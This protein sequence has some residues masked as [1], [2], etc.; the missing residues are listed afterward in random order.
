MKKLLLGSIVL[1]VFSSSVAIFQMSC[2]KTSNAQTGPGSYTSPGI[3]LYDKSSAEIWKVKVDGTGN[4]K[5]NIV[6]PAGVQFQIGDGGAYKL[7]G[8]GQNIIFQARNTT[9]NTNQLYRCNL[10]GGD[11]QIVLESPDPI[12]LGSAI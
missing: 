1:T 3:V 10:S 6:L 8:D 2:N 4:E 5:V 12:Q 9:S 7:T 11:L